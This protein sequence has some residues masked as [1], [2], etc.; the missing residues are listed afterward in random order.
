[1]AWQPMLWIIHEAARTK[2]DCSIPVIKY[3]LQRLTYS[4]AYDVTLLVEERFYITYAYIRT[5]GI[6]SILLIF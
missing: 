4:Q 2:F 5:D 6:V 1:M 3:L